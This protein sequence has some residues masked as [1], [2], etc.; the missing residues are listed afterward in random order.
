[1]RPRSLLAVLALFGAPVA[2]AATLHVPADYPTVAAALSAAVAGDTV[3][4]APGRYAESGLAVPGGVTLLAD[5]S[6]G[7][8]AWFDGLDADTPILTIPVNAAHVRIEGLTFR[9]AHPALVV[10]AGT[11]RHEVVQCTF[12]ECR[13]AVQG[14]RFDVRGSRFEDNTDVAL[15]AKD[16]VVESCTFRRNS[17]RGLGGAVSMFPGSV[18]NCRFEGNESGGG[19]GIYSLGGD[20]TDCTFVDNRARDDTD[21]G[22]VYLAGPTPVSG[23]VF[24]RNHAGGD[25]GAIFAR[26]R[27]TNVDRCR[28]L[29]NTSTRG[30]AILVTAAHLVVRSSTFLRNAADKGGAI[31]APTTPHRTLTLENSVIQET[32]SGGAISFNPEALTPEL[33][34]CDLFGNAGGDWIDRLAGLYPGN[35]NLSVDGLFCDDP[36]DS[37]FVSVSSPLLAVNNRRGEDVGDSKPAC[38]VPGVLVTSQPFGVPLEVDGIAY[39]SPTVFPWTPGSVHTL[40]APVQLDPAI[41]V[42]LDFTS[43]SD[44]GARSHSIVAPAGDAELTAGYARSFRVTTSADVGGAVEPASGLVAEGTPL[45]L[46]A[47]PDSGAVFAGWTGTGAGAY[48]GPSASVAIDLQGPVAEHAH[49]YRPPASGA[50]SLTVTGDPGGLV[51]PPS[52]PFAPGESVRISALPFTGSRFVKWVGEGQDSYSGERPD[53][54]IVM[55]SDIVQ[56][57]LF[58]PD[59]TLHGVDFS[60][61]ASA[62]DPFRNSVPPTGGARPVYL[63]LTCSQGGISA[64]ECGVASSLP[65]EQFVPGEGVINFGFGEDLVLTMDRCPTGEPV[66]RLLGQW[67]AQD[68]G[69]RICLRA[70]R[71]DRIFAT[72]DCGSFPTLWPDP[73]VRGFASDGTAPCIVGHNGCSEPAAATDVPI[74]AAPAITGLSGVAPNPFRGTTEVRFSLA[75][76]GVAKVALYDVAGRLVRVLR[77]EPLPAG[78]HAVTWDGRTGSARAAPGIYFVRFEAAGTRETRRVVFLGD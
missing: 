70:S 43:W 55:H 3:L 28:F 73:L 66:H 48:T 2:H 4:L 34:A 32:L 15:S 22:A 59:G 39:G 24:L 44:G 13:G 6:P 20:I 46:Q 18:R 38:H 16:V 75:Q 33:T 41:G 23:C 37:L 11:D 26:D 19:G 72:V 9:N 52:G 42:H 65:L 60:L 77:D 10:S 69:G 54:T 49:F 62:T 5:L 71:A 17:S 61:S 74:A 63:W 64:F 45:I 47:R 51:F 8:E 30:G 31:L 50:F 56:H 76:A 68:T 36:E 53:P 78:S 29:G 35:G 12:R 40:V 27:T 57:A 1:M 25:G 14:T 21:G 67:M 58:V 7:A